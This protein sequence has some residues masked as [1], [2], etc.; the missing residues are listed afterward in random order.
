MDRFS[1][2]KE[3]KTEPNFLTQISQNEKFKIQNQDHFEQ[4]LKKVNK[5]ANGPPRRKHQQK[6]RSR[7]QSNS[8]S[9]TR[10][11]SS[12]NIT[13]NISTEPPLFHITHSTIVTK[14]PVGCQIHGSSPRLK[15]VKKK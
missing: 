3:Y 7:S 1:I 9:I 2:N 11:P 12:N 6:K 10:S 8:A 5:I 14:K 13:N 4:L 15:R